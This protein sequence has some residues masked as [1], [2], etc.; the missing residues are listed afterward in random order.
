MSY[1][2]EKITTQELSEKYPV[3][4]YEH[5][6]ECSCG[7]SCPT[8]MYAVVGCDYYKQENPDKAY[9]TRG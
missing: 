1:I 2:L 8:C 3:A 9:C 4:N 7:L 5:R 6:D